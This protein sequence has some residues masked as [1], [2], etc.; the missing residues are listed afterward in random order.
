MSR[1]SDQKTPGD[2]IPARGPHSRS[3]QL[4]RSDPS[5]TRHKPWGGV[6]RRKIGDSVGVASPP[7]ARACHTNTKHQTLAAEAVIIS[8]LPG[9]I[10]SSRAPGFGGR[11]GHGCRREAEPR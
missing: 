5:V 10:H 3:I 4:T 7:V 8:V 6:N 2:I 1:P 9:R 11:Y